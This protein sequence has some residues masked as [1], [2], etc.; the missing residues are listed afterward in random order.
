MMPEKKKNLLIEL[1][2]SWFTVVIC[3]HHF[4]MY[5]DALPFGGGYIAVDFFFI[6]SGYYLAMHMGKNK[7]GSVS[8]K[9]MGIYLINRY[10]RLLPPY[11]LAFLASS[12]VSIFYLHRELKGTIG[13]Y[14]REA[15]MVEIGFNSSSARMNSPDW[16]CGCLLLATLILL[17]ILAIVDR[18]KIGK[19]IYL[20]LAMLAYLFFFWR[21]GH[22]NIFPNEAA[23]L[24]ASVIRGAAG[25]SLGVWIN[26][27]QE[28]EKKILPIHKLLAAGLLIGISY[29]VL[30]DNAYSYTDYIVIAAFAALFIICIQWSPVCS[31]TFLE[32]TILFG[33]KIS[34]TIYLNH[35]MVAYI[36]TNQRMFEKLDWKAQS[37]LYFFIVFLI[38]LGMYF[39]W[40]V[41]QGLLPA[42]ARKFFL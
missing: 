14:I 33:G 38:S 16:Y 17:C 5:S 37:L 2:R 4:R 6:I 31:N 9:N 24:D 32:K 7:T 21:Y 40:K 1:L 15:L 35:F 3:L 30:W 22:I 39:L 8:I 13:G 20:S 11:L 19:S 27:R 23:L 28:I 26:E 34:Y 36:V 29:M 12:L 41:V 18:L 10:K 25:L 42:K